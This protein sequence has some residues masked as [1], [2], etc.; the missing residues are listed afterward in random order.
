MCSGWQNMQTS[1]RCM[2]R[3]TSAGRDAHAVR[4]P[5]Q[6]PDLMRGVHQARHQARV[7]GREQP[8]RDALLEAPR[9]Q[10]RAAPRRVHLALAREQR[11][12]GPHV[13]VA[14]HAQV[15]GVIHEVA[16]VR[17]HSPE[18]PVQQGGSATWAGSR[19]P[20]ELGT[21]SRVHRLVERF[22]ALE[23]LVH[24]AGRDL[25]ERRHVVHLGRAE[26]VLREHALGSIE[27]DAPGQLLA[28]L[29]HPRLGGRGGQT[30]PTAVGGHG[31]LTCAATAAASSAEMGWSG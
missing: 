27:D 10:R 20:E 14:E 7:T 2:R 26:P 29:A 15:V 17:R 21:M 12:L 30:Q 13:D 31:R 11:L 28:R 18:Q 23:Q 3:M 9:D 24:G 4:Q 25:G 16:R 6:Q 22:L 1:S 19:P 8:R 5:V